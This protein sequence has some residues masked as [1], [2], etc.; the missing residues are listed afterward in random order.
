MSAS[1]TRPFKAFALACLA[2]TLILAGC[3]DPL[4]PREPA[5]VRALTVFMILDPDAPAQ[6]ALIAP[7]ATTDTLPALT[8]EFGPANGEATV[9][10][11]GAASSEY[12]ALRSCLWTYGSIPFRTAAPPRCLTFPATP[13]HGERY[14]VTIAAPGWTPATGTTRVPGEFEIR[15]AVARGDPPGTRGIEIHWTRSQGVYRYLVGLRA[16]VPPWDCGFDCYAPPDRQGW[17]EATTDTTLK[18]TITG[19]AA[20]ELT[21][22]T[23]PWYVDVYAVD[24]AAYDFLMTG[25]TGELFSV[26]P[27]QNV[28]GGYGAIGSWVRRSVRVGG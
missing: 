9:Q 1:E 15:S 22:T 4:A 25:T 14:R 19:A 13:H 12:T 11:T 28:E 7:T 6:S 10:A 17:F 18:T 8:G 3:D 16:A 5:E 27:I 24:R 2:G 26:P 21:G 20:E 23:G